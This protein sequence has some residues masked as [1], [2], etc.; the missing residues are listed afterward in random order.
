MTLFH[1]TDF[2][3]IYFILA[4][5]FLHFSYSQEFWQQSTEGLGSGNIQALAVSPDFISDNLILAGTWAGHLEDGGGIY[6]SIDAGKTWHA[7]NEGLTNRTIEVIRFSPDYANDKT[8][9]IASGILGGELFK[10]VDGAAT[11]TKL[12]NGIPSNLPGIEDVVILLSDKLTLK[13]FPK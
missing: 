10:S 3:G 11:W 1:S 4:F 7:S 13:I 8:V 6:K 12:T 5:D 2:F 9:F